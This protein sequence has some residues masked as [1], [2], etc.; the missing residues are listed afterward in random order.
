MFVLNKDSQSAACSSAYL[1]FN[2]PMVE[3]SVWGPACAMPSVGSGP[4]QTCSNGGS[5]CGYH[6]RRLCPHSRKDCPCEWLCPKS[7]VNPLTNLLDYIC[8][9]GD[10]PKMGSFHPSE[11]F[12]ASQTHDFCNSVIIREMGPDY[13]SWSLENWAAAFS[14]HV[15][16][17]CWQVRMWHWT[18]PIRMR[19]SQSLLLAEVGAGFAHLWGSR[20]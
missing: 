15:E 14:G 2:I 20:F 19:R 18:W 1:S 12:P 9:S 10:G 7:P 3:V 13:T 16:G 11:H 5:K 8:G 4:A 17:T 6:K